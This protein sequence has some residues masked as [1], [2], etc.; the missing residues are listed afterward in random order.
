M[1]TQ[2][3]SNIKIPAFDKTNYTLWKM[4]MLLFIKMANPLYVQILKNGSFTPMER[5][6]ESTDGDMV[7]P[8]YYTPKDPSKYTEPEKEKVSLDSGLQLILIESLDNVMD[9]N[10]INCDA[11]KQIWEKIEILCE[12]T[13]ELPPPLTQ[14]EKNRIAQM[15]RNNQRLDE[16]EVKRLVIQLNGFVAR[17]IKEKDKV[18]EECVDYI[19]ENEDED[20]NDD[21]T[22]YA[23]KNEYMSPVTFASATESRATHGSGWTGDTECLVPRFSD[24][25][26]AEDVDNSKY[27]TGYSFT[28]GGSIVS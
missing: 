5:V 7:I 23:E 27:M 14:I 20:D 4:K 15:Q 10:I 22:E 19:P 12:R 11:A 18:Q 28:L 6:E 9:N 2:K 17:K 16:L 13:E 3:I 25:D 26:Y 21:T 1:N 24:S 8:A